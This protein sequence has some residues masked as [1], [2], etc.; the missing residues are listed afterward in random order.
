MTNSTIAIVG[1]N[2]KTGARV[3]NQLSALGYN[4]RALSR[5]SDYAFD[6]ADKNGWQQALQGAQ[7]AYVTYYP[8]LAV[9]QAEADIRDFVAT[10]K[11][12]GL[13]HIVLLSGRGEDGAQRAE[14]VVQNSGLTWNIVRASWF[15]QNF[16]ESFMLD[17]IA[18]GE[19]VLP[20]PKA[21]EPFIDVDDI[22]EV[23]VA[24]LTRS[25]LANQLLEVTGP[26]LLSF[27][28]CVQAIAKATGRDIGFKTAPIDAYLAGAKAQGL[29]EDIAWLINELFVNVLDGRNENTT[30]TIEAVLGRPARSI[31]EYIAAT[32]KTGV[33]APQPT[34]T[35]TEVA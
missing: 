11:A 34:S 22:A 29:P 14:A 16:S 12:A 32:V 8:D 31:Q 35:S 23:A 20:Q 10:A 5:S 21:L 25:D 28:H 30:N 13:Q 26:E 2:G 15:M 6:W 17:G 1:A 18:A 7:T 27:D 24:A 4:T 9:P 33:W 19:L 3:L